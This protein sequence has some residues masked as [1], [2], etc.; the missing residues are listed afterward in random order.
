MS[1]VKGHKMK[2]YGYVTKSTRF[3]KKVFKG[4]AQGKR[5]KGGHR[6]RWK[7]YPGLN[8]FGTGRT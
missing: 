7:E 4:T 5:I 8:G 1:V 6:K 3:A 2:W